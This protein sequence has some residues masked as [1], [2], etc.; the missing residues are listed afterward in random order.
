MENLHIFSAT[1]N[2]KRE[3][4]TGNGSW[5]GENAACG[6]TGMICHNCQKSGVYFCAKGRNAALLLTAG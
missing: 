3:N 4:L 6:G 5:G 1:G 2:G